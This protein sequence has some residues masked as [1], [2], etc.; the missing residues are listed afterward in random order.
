MSFPAVAKDAVFV[1]VDDLANLTD[2]TTSTFTSADFTNFNWRGIIVTFDN[3]TF[4]GGTNY[5]NEIDGKDTKSGKYY[6]LSTDSAQTGTAT[7]VLAVYPGIGA[8]ANGINIANGLPLP[9]TFRFKITKTGA[10]SAFTSTIGCAA[11]L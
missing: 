10:F 2:S 8:A 5:T 1:N 11:I 4:T 6:I 3:T 9:R 7:R